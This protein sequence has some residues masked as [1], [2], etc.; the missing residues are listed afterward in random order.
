MLRKISEQEERVYRL[1]H[2]DFGK[3]TTEETAK[4]MRISKSKV[5]RLLKILKAKAPQLFPILS[6]RQHHIYQL[7]TDVGLSQRAIAIR[8]G[9]TQPNIQAILNRLKKKGM[10]L[11]EPHGI[12]NMVAYEN[13]VDEFVI[14]KF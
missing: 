1:R 6:P 4:K 11:L 9:S 8:L 14:H 2:H 10:S 13:G 12:G 3:L 5:R 7:Y